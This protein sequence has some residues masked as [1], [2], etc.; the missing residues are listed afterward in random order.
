MF[1]IDNIRFERDNTALS[2]KDANS[3]DFNIYP[4]PA[5][6]HIKITTKENSNIAIINSIGMVVKSIKKS[7]KNHFVSIENLSSGLYFIE[8]K[9]NKKIATKKLII[10]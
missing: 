4:N 8:I 1:Y 7:K 10:Q 3:F 9:H 2:L 5:K 6:T